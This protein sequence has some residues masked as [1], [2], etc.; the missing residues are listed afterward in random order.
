MNFLK[1]TINIRSGNY[2]RLG[3]IFLTILIF[4]TTSYADKTAPTN[5]HQPVAEHFKQSF[6][7]ANGL[8]MKMSKRAVR[9]AHITACAHAQDTSKEK[10][11]C[12][13]LNKK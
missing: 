5:K 8:K 4:S 12:K 11:V 3:F 2:F 10:D 13:G 9:F 1:K 7:V 6:Q